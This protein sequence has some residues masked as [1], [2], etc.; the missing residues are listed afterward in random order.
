MKFS[1]TVASALAALHLSCA[2]PTTLEKRTVTGYA[3]R[4]FTRNCTNPHICTYIFTIDT[5]EE[6]QPCTVIDETPVLL[7]RTGPTAVSHP[8]YGKVCREVGVKTT[9]RIDESH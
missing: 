8:W 4:N 9:A 5:G 1:T 7:K 3:V 2:A 6:K